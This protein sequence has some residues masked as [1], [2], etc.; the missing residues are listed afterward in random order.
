MTSAAMPDPVFNEPVDYALRGKVFKIREVEYIFARSIGIAIV[1]MLLGVSEGKSGA[2]VI[3]AQLDKASAFVA[4]AT[5]EDSAYLEQLPA[6]MFVN[7]FN[8]VLEAH[9]GLL[10]EL[11]LTRSLLL[12]LVPKNQQGSGPLNS[13]SPLPGPGSTTAPLGA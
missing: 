12:G 8:R 9:Q 1:E 3:D 7:L 4:K 13:T 5:G 11:F 10:Q 2:Q 6:S